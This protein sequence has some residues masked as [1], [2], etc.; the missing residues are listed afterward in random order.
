MPQALPIKLGAMFTTGLRFSSH[1]IYATHISLGV[2]FL[3]GKSPTPGY[4]C[5]EF[6]SVWKVN[7]AALLARWFCYG[8][9]RKV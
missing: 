7:F 4:K 2:E 3:I 8:A 1:A 9:T 5:A 6:G